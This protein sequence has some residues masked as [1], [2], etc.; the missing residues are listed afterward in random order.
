[1]RWLAIVSVKL[2]S[3]VSTDVEDLHT[4]IAK[5]NGR[6]ATSYGLGN[7]KTK[8]CEHCRYWTTI[9]YICQSNSQQSNAVWYYSILASSIL[10]DS[11][12]FP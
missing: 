1:M 12:G 10:P 11:V 9:P 7:V 8:H 2:N 6:Q 3:V 4:D 5:R